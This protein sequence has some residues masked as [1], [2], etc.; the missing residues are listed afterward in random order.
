MASYTSS[1]RSV[2]YVTLAILFH[3]I[4]LYSLYD[5]CYPESHGSMMT[6]VAD[7]QTHTLKPPADRVVMFAVKGLSLDYAFGLNDNDL[8]H[9]GFIRNIIRREGRWGVANTSSVHLWNNDHITGVDT[10]TYDNPSDSIV[11]ACQHAWIWG[12][13]RIPYMT[14][15]TVEV[16]STTLC[17]DNS[18]LY[19][20]W[21]SESLE[22]LLLIES[23]E[24]IV[25]DQLNQ[26]KTIFL[27]NMDASGCKDGHCITEHLHRVDRIINTTTNLIHSY[28]SD[29]R[30]AF[31]L[32][33]TPN[34]SDRVPFIT[35]GAGIKQPRSALYGDY[36][37][38]DNFST[39]WKL[40]KFERIDLDL[41]DVA[42]LAAVLLGVRIP[43]QS[44]GILPHGY[45]HYNKEFQAE[46]MFTNAKQF[47]QRVQ[48]IED[49]VRN[50]SLSFMFRPFK[51]LKPSDRS[52]F[53]QNTESLIKKRKLQEV[54]EDCIRIIQVSK[55][56]IEYFNKYHETSLKASLTL[57]FIGWLVY[58]AQLLFKEGSINYNPFKESLPSIP[59]IVL[60]F[61]I[62]SLQYHQ[63]VKVSY[64]VYH[65]L[66]CLCWDFVLKNHTSVFRFI[67]ANIKRD[68]NQFIVNV[69][70]LFFLF[71]GLE[72]VFLGLVHHGAWLTVIMSVIGLAVPIV[73]LGRQCTIVI[74]ITWSIPSIIIGATPFYPRFSLITPM[75]PVTLIIAFLILHLYLQ[76]NPLL[77]YRFTTPRIK[78]CR[79]FNMLTIDTMVCL[80]TCMSIIIQPIISKV[81]PP[82]QGV[83]ITIA[84]FLLFL[85]PTSVPGRLLHISTLLYV[86][87]H[88]VCDQSYSIL[89]FSLISMLFSVLCITD[90]TH[91]GKLIVNDTLWSGV[92]GCLCY[93]D[94]ATCT[95]PIPP[96]SASINDLF[97]SA[98][99][100]LLVIIISNV[101]IFQS[102]TPFSITI[103][104]SL[105]ISDH[106]PSIIAI[107]NVVIPLLYVY[108]TLNV[109]T[110]KLG[111]SLS[112]V[113]CSLFLLMDT[114]AIQAYL[115]MDVN[116]NCE[117]FV[118][119]VLNAIVCPCL[120]LLA[121]LVTGDSIIP[122]K[123]TDNE[124]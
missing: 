67:L 21:L 64:Y 30:T 118:V 17:N 74:C 103:Q 31:L 116:K 48:A 26:D 27:I 101:V 39:K 14:S 114:L 43:L 49:Y 120:F 113:F 2:N 54:I 56:A 78:L 32:L 91:H 44:N 1:W 23:N 7:P 61:V 38:H 46:T 111:T 50:Q 29:Q 25:A 96:K 37:Y 92:F 119:I 13:N 3:L 8:P 12:C 58:S 79:P 68:S 80:F 82:L 55:E 100:T 35:W 20:T 72:V 94:F 75:M 99:S 124:N 122:R 106:L 22:H 28:F 5:L 33:G 52:E 84:L 97:R 107:M 42:P 10:P 59:C 85:G 95:I 34:S 98:F 57:S 62:I 83:T 19:N 81:V 110:V 41:V 51:H 24:E 123:T 102:S 89:L 40:D 108:S 66:P 86:I 90:L 77:N 73:T 65:C 109:I 47:M 16:K 53:I 6:T 115:I 87:F 69:V 117:L 71:I 63:N 11:D 105:V 45:I 88:L 9:M 104:P 93:S 18:S 4:W 70:V 112:I 121:R 36:R 15:E 60:C 76:C